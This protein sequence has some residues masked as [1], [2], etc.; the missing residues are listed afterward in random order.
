VNS[1]G[2]NCSLQKETPVAHACA[3]QLT[4]SN[5]M[6]DARHSLIPYFVCCPTE[7]SPVIQFC[8]WGIGHNTSQ[9]NSPEIKVD[10]YDHIGIVITP[11]ILQF[12]SFFFF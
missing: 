3:Y 6:V 2:L 8:H 5:N 1:K 9:S 11:L 7:Q 10:S 12:V 4:C